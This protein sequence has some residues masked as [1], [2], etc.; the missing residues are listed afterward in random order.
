MIT[1]A[2]Y[3]ERFGHG[4]GHSL[5]LQIHEL[6]RLSQTEETVLEPGWFVRGGT[7]IYLTGWGGIRIENVV[8]VTE[9]GI[10]NLTTSP[11]R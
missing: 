4:L 10:E 2:G 9:E 7:G 1:A 8:V 11:K 6:P 5:G 3:G